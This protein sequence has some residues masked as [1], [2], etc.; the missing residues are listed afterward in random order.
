MVMVRV[1]FRNE[2]LT[3]AFFFDIVPELGVE[4]TICKSFHVKG[5]VSIFRSDYYSQKYFIIKNWLINAKGG[6]PHY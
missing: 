4:G 1:D 3:R 5:F 6:N 2:I